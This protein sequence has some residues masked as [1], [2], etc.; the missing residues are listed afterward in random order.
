MQEHNTGAAFVGH[1]YQRSRRNAPCIKFTQTED[2]YSSR[3]VLTVA[4]VRFRTGVGSLGIQAAAK[5]Y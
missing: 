3:S 4:E 5:R 1:A 2:I